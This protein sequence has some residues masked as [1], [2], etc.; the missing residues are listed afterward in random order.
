MGAPP[1][2]E[3][4]ADLLRWPRPEPPTS[5][6]PAVTSAAA[7]M[8]ATA[9]V[10]TA[11]IPAET[12]PVAPEVAA[13]ADPAT[14]VE[15]AT[16]LDPAAAVDPATAVELAAAVVPAA[17]PPPAEAPVPAAEVAAVAPEPAEWP[18]W[19]NANCLSNASG[20]NGSSA[21]SA[22]FVSRS[23]TRK[24]EQRSQ[25]RRCRRTGA[26]GR[27]LRPSATSPSSSRT[28]SQL[29]KRAS[30]A[31]A[32][33]TRARTSSDLTLGTVVSIVSAICS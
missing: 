7:A 27:R 3:A 13:T 14:A 8:P 22:L 9:L 12:K 15:P 6:A 31:S 26:L 33:E 23:W 10:A 4:E 5:T 1:T 25:V 18:T 30:A 2:T 11:P 19:M 24:V 29:N 17:A 16:A 32:S 20:P 28:W 21:A